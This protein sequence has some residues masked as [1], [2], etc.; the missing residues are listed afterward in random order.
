MLEDRVLFFRKQF[1]RSVKHRHRLWHLCHLYSVQVKVVLLSR[2]LAFVV[3][4]DGF[5][6]WINCEIGFGVKLNNFYEPLLQWRSV[7]VKRIGG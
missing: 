2:S 1:L 6:G 4:R 3:K 7:T 5:E